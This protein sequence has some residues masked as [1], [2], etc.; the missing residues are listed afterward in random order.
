MGGLVVVAGGSRL[1]SLAVDSYRSANPHL[2]TDFY[3]IPAPSAA[4]SGQATVAAGLILVG[5]AAVLVSSL[6]RIRIAATGW[7]LLRSVGALCPIPIALVLAQPGLQ[8]Y[9]QMYV[10][11]LCGDCTPPAPNPPWGAFAL[12]VTVLALG[13]LVSLAV[14]LVLIALAIFGFLGRKRLPR[15]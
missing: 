9:F 13:V 2:G 14:S 7:L 5:L 8:G 6:M 15:H 1:F 3:N 4:E 11:T 12:G 10:N